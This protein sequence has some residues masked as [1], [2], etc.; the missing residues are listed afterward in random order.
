[1]RSYDMMPTLLQ[2]LLMLSLFLSLCASAYLLYAT[3]HRRSLGLSLPTLLCALLSSGMMI[4]YSADVRSS[5]HGYPLSPLS[6][7]LCEKPVVLPLVLLALMTAYLVYSY[8][9]ELALLRTTVSPSAIK[10]SIDHLNTGLC[11]YAENG[12]VMLVNHCMNR[13][14]HIMLG[15]DL[16]NAALM[17]EDICGGELQPGVIRHNV[18]S[19]PSFTL[20]DETVWTFSRTE[21]SGV[22]QITA[23]DT[24]E[25]HRLVQELEQKNTALAALQ[26]R[27]RQYEL[28]VEELTRAR[29]RLQA[30]SRIHSDLGQTLTASRR[31][32]QDAQMER[33]IPMDAWRQSI[34]RLRQKFQNA[35]EG[36]SLETMVK[37]AGSFGVAV[38]IEGVLPRQ[39]RAAQLFLEAGAEALTNAVR[40]AGARRLSVCFTETDTHTQVCFRNDGPAPAEPITEGGGLGS[41]RRKVETAGGTMTIATRPEF[42]LTITMR[43][44]GGDCL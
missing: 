21:L 1:M 24:T 19:Q 13:L 9:R 38:E 35:D 4:L 16:Q 20:P 7:W 34:S 36:I 27:L 14:C 42:A 22:L 37:T 6:R 32:L 28:D 23:A 33:T 43:K 30:K 40:H 15:R 2:I 39:E 11:F 3:F 12:R 29:E 8:R 18:G 31:Y 41:L 10:E 5:K 44:N 25:F 17:W 26:Q